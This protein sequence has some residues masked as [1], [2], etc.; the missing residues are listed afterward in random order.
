MSR[1]YTQRL[2]RDDDAIRA[3]YAYVQDESNAPNSLQI[4]SK[5]FML[6]HALREA[7]LAGICHERDRE[8]EDD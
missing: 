7:F 1:T 8:V 6:H 5:R 2:L 3:A 4:D